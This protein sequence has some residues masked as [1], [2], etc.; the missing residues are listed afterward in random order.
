[1]S[2]MVVRCVGALIY[3]ADGRLLLIRRANPP[4]R[5]RWSLPGGRV[6][7]GETDEQAVIREVA[8][9]TGL[10]VTTGR[11][12]GT[13]HRPGPRIGPGPRPGKDSG[14]D[15]GGQRPERT[16]TFAIYDYECQVVGGAPAAGSD[17]SGLCWV[18]AAALDALDG[19]GALVDLLAETLRGWQ[20]LPERPS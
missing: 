7:S 1:M 13:V 19:C 2:E 12:V 5:W 14:D 17:A 16:V 8:E 18:D 3:A 20:A 10:T 6:E 15:S 11:L 9:E 4:G